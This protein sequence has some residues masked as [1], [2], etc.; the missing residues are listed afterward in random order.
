MKDCKIRRVRRG[1]NPRW[2]RSKLSF[3]SLYF[4]LCHG[5]LDLLFSLPTTS[6][7][8]SRLEFCSPYFQAP[9]LIFTK[10]RLQRSRNSGVTNSPFNVASKFC[11]PNAGFQATRPFPNEA[12]ICGGAKTYVVGTKIILKRPIVRGSRRRCLWRRLLLLVYLFILD[13]LEETKPVDYQAVY[14]NIAEILENNDY[15]DGNLESLNKQAAM[16]PFCSGWLGTPLELTVF[17]K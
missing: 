6:L 1:T 4:E 16:A 17:P 9:M 12:V 5:R 14:S 11:F 8:I 3:Q 13:Y 15:D 10:F 2:L 7:S